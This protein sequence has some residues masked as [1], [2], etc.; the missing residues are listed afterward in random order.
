MGTTTSSNATPLRIA[1][2]LHNTPV[3][4]FHLLTALTAGMGFFTDGEDPG[5]KSAIGDCR[6]QRPGLK[7]AVS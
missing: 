5:K 6:Q 1:D 4:F 2:S 3:S 7:A